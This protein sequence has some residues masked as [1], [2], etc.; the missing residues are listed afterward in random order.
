MHRIQRAIC[1]FALTA[2]AT[3]PTLH[4]HA[5][6]A[7]PEQ[8]PG[9]NVEPSQATKVQ[10]ANEKVTLRVLAVKGKGRE[11]LPIAN[12]T[13]IFDMRNNGDAVET[14]VVRFPITDPSGYGDG[15]G[16]QPEIRNVVVK[17]NGRAV[18]TR[19]VTTANPQGPK[20]PEVKWAAFEVT[21]PP[22]KIPRLR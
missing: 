3:L 2:L 14:M 16:G 21:F 19:I 15:F 5:D 10:M 12:V 11:E 22:G 4:A 1:A 17:V 20:E 7:P 8:A 13:A 18:N 9:S 6:V